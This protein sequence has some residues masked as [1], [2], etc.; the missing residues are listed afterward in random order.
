MGSEIHT[1]RDYKLSVTRQL[2]YEF[3]LYNA[4]ASKSTHLYYVLTK[5]KLCN[6]LKCSLTNINISAIIN[7]NLRGVTFSINHSVCFGVMSF[8]RS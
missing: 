8:Y 7:F 1:V 4:R 6:V 2:Q 5:A 3:M